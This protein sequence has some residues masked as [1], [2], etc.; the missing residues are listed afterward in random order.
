MKHTNLNVIQCPLT[1]C[2][3]CPS[4]IA[5]TCEQLLA[6]KNNNTSKKVI[7]L[8]PERKS[9]HVGD[10]GDNFP[11]AP[12]WISNGWETIFIDEEIDIL[13]HSIDLLDVYFVG[14]YLSIFYRE[15]SSNQIIHRSSPLIK[16]PLELDLLHKL[17]SQHDYFIQPQSMTR[18]RLSER[19]QQAYSDAFEHISQSIPEI[20]RKTRMRIAEITAHHKTVLGGLFPI[21]FDDKVE[22]I[23]LDMP[24]SP[25][26]F[27]HQNMG[28][29][30]SDTTLSTKDEMR[31]ITLLRAESNLHL[32]K[33]NPSLKSD[34]QILGTTLRISISI[35]P[36]SPDGLHLEIRRAKSKPFTLIELIR[37]GTLTLEA[38]ATLL[39]AVSSRFNI[40]I[41]GAPGVGKTTLLNA[42]DMTTPR[43]W[44][45]IY[46]EDVLESRLLQEHHQVRI[47]VN[48]VDEINARFQKSTEIIKSLHRSPDYLILGEIQTMEHSQALF[49]AITAG[50]HTIQTCH[51]KSAASL[52]SR[53]TLNH[54]I[55]PSNIALMDIIVTLDRPI[56]GQSKRVLREIVEIKRDLVDGLLVFSGLNTIY[57]QAT[58]NK[59]KGWAD[60]GAFLTQAHD[61][62]LENHHCII[63][64]LVELL[65]NELRKKIGAPS[66]PLGEKLWDNIH[67]ME[68]SSPHL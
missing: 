29:C 50:L 59:L 55:N 66:I 31:L 18:I 36:L 33:S 24:E 2:N 39:L 6:I 12:P 21:L 38:A 51:S 64:S 26:Y 8:E 27:D 43:W 25:I 56:P 19:I 37:N 53:W 1:R 60:N 40:T 13:N 52:V 32:D 68:Y 54:R 30:I 46:I 17:C 45:K 44:R 15:P 49:Q 10:A 67:P 41:T 63:N 20:S 57:N 3:K 34:L 23:Y 9:I 4:W 35:P 5:P 7:L 48:P 28:R 11:T 61:I 14:P 16:T 58:D 22:E 65:R 62:G 42:L 47:R